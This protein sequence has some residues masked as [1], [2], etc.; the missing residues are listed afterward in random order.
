VGHA[1]HA[2]NYLGA[3]AFQR[4]LAPRY[5]Q[6]REQV[7]LLNGRL[8]NNLAGM[9]TIKSFTAENYEI[10]RV[11]AESEA[12]RLSNQ[13]AI[14]LSALFIPLIRVLILFGF[15]A[16]LVY[17][18][19]ATVA[20]HLAVGTYSVLVFITQ[21][22]LW[23]L[24]RLGETLDQ[25]QR[26][27]ASTQRV[28]DLLD[29][30]IA[31]CPGQQRLAAS[32]IQGNIQFEAVS[33]TYPNREPVI[34]RLNLS[35]PAGQTIAIVGSTGSGKSTLVKL[36]LRFY[37]VGEGRITLDG[38]DIRDLNPE[39]LRRAI[40]LVS[41]DVFLF[42]G[43]VAE[44]IAYGSFAA[45]PEAIAW[46]AQMAEAD[47]F[48]QALPQGYHTLVGSGVKSFREG[49]ASGWRSPGLF[50]KTR[51]FWSWMR[52]PRRWITKPRRRSSDP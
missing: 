22:L 44:N 11:S 51:R 40:G 20:G 15:T 4:L 8:A 14:A 30:P 26:A 45:S 21:R 27:M 39:D 16:T 35:I 6:V 1:A 46:A 34:Q 47:G 17:G 19:L 23:P 12:Y 24:T 29:T 3:I 9:M 2:L 42:H 36:L 38:L 13:R 25:Y 43:T 49:S 32:Q 52:P 33:F 28:L 5:A 18:G 41:Q 50:S 7:G 31:I 37:E 48:I 10:E